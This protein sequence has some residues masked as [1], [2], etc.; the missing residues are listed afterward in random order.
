MAAGEGALLMLGISVQLETMAYLVDGPL[1][2]WLHDT[3]PVWL[4]ASC[5]GVVGEQCRL[6]QDTEMAVACRSLS[7][8]GRILLWRVSRAERSILTRYC[9]LS[10][11]S[12]TTPDLSHLF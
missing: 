7:R 1:A 10:P 4:P 3:D 2:Q 6:A 8:A 5:L 12:T 11:T 9:S